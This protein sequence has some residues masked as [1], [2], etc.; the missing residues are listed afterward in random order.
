MLARALQIAIR[1]QVKHSPFDIGPAALIL[2]TVG[3]KVS[4]DAE[5][6]RVAILPRKK[7]SEPIGLTSAIDSF[8]RLTSDFFKLAFLARQRGGWRIAKARGL[9]DEKV[10]DLVRDYTEGPDWGVLGEPGVNV[11]KLNLTLDRQIST[12]SNGNPTR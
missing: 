2:W 3:R 6:F 1:I 11:L 9:S 7:L 5:S 4:D 8:R 12:R 10:R